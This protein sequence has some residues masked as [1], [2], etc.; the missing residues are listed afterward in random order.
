MVVGSD[1]FSLPQLESLMQEK[2]SMFDVIIIGGGPAGLTAGLYC[3]RAGLKTVLIEKAMLGGKVSL[4]SEIDNYPGFPSGITGMELSER[5]EVQ[6]KRFDVE[7]VWG[8]VTGLE[9]EGEVKKVLLSDKVFSGKTIIIAAGCEPK[10]ISVPGEDE[11]RGRGVSYCATCDGAFYKDKKI[12]VVG[13]GNSAISEAIFLTRFG[14]GVTV[15][16]RRD[17]LRAEKIL[18]D[19]AIAHPKIDFEWSSTVTKINGQNKVESVEIQDLVSGSKK[20]LKTDGVFIYIGDIPN[21]DFL[22][23]KVDFSKDKSIIVDNA[24]KTNVSGVFAAGDICTKDLRQIATAVGDGAIA[25]DSARKY[26]EN[27]I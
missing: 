27:V 6:A 5:M 4:C 19:S 7:V 9:L 24:M 22:E 1:V 8:D 23:G 15:I 25:A 10:K 20:T 14:S 17:K 3:G 16:H 18:A 2:N 12:V 11:L 21:T 26:L 13:G